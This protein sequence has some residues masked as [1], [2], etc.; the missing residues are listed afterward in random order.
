VRRDGEGKGGCGGYGGKRVLLLVLML[1][2]K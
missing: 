2:P 1:L